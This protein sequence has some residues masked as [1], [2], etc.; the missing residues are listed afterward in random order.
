MRRGLGYGSCVVDETSE[1]HTQEAVDKYENPQ[2]ATACRIEAVRIL[3][4][5]RK[6]VGLACLAVAAPAAV[7]VRTAADA[8]DASDLPENKAGKSLATIEADL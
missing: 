8:I 6:V 7:I 4:R 2:E 1:V 3:A 5:A